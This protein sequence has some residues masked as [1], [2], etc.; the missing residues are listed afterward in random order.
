LQ[1]RPSIASSACRTDVTQSK[2]RY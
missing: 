1:S 2:T